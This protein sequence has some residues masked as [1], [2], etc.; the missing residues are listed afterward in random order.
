MPG[1]SLGYKSRLP[2][3]LLTTQLFNN[4]EGV[5]S[6]VN[7]DVVTDL[8]LH[9]GWI[10]ADEVGVGKHSQWQRLRGVV[11][12]EEKNFPQHEEYSLVAPI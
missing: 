8:N 9:C 12:D 6:P 2:H 7:E 3:S 1:S 4:A 5:S 11:T 10:G